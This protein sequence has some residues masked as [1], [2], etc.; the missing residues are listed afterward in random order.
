MVV[1]PQQLEA[2]RQRLVA[3]QQAK[4][5]NAAAQAGAMTAQLDKDR[6]RL[7]AKYDAIGTDLPQAW[8]ANKKSAEHYTDPVT[9][10]GSVGSVFAMPACRWR[11]A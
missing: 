3:I 1:S 10:F 5:A 9:A 6:A 2:T 7:N 11:P 4:T 8:D